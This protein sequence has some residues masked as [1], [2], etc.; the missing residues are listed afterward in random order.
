MTYTNQET[1][2]YCLRWIYNFHEGDLETAHVSYS[3]GPNYHWNKYLAKIKADVNATQAMTEVV[4][5]MDNEG[6]KLLIEW[7]MMEN[8]NDIE[9]QREWEQ[10]TVAH[11]KKQ[12]T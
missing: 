8:K 3:C 10:L 11:L 2:H 5:N 9:Q 7:I 1:L 4:L 6:Q 12:K